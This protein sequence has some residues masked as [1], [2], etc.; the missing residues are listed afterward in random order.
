M[1]MVDRFHASGLTGAVLVCREAF[2]EGKSQGNTLLEFWHH[3][4]AGRVAFV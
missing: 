2:M 3:A 4:V 1:R